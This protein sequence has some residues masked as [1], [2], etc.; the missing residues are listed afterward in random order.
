MTVV[1]LAT[2]PNC[3]ADPAACLAIFPFLCVCALVSS[4]SALLQHDLTA[5][6]TVRCATFAP[7]LA[8]MR[9]APVASTHVIDLIITYRA[10]P[11]P[12][13]GTCAPAW[14]QWWS[15]RTAPAT[16]SPLTTLAWVAR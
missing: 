1:V 13:S 6:A 8:H 14:V 2:G 9:T 3:G 15:P 5:T 16:P 7:W 11:L 12:G 4:R 10:F